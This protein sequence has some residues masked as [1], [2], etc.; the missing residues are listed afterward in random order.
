MCPQGLRIE[1]LQHMVS[2]LEVDM[3]VESRVTSE[4]QREAMDSKDLAQ[5]LLLELEEAKNDIV[6]Q[7]LIQKALT[8]VRSFAPVVTE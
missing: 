5:K 7:D 6:N 3:E 4:A 1:V 8:Q 2:R